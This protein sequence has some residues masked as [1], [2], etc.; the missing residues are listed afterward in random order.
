MPTETHT[1]EACGMGRA[2]FR[3]D[4]E[5]HARWVEAFEAKPL[6]LHNDEPKDSPDDRGGTCDHCGKAIRYTVPVISAD[7]KR[8]IVGTTCATQMGNEGLRDTAQEMLK[9]RQRKQREAKRVAKRE[10]KHARIANAKELLKSHW[11]HFAR[12]EHPHGMQG[13]LADYLEF[14]LKQWSEKAAIQI[15]RELAA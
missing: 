9:K 2:P 13:S 15:E 6:G 8:S 14:C 11:D 10:K 4:S 3:F 1:F 12:Q 7:G 5:R